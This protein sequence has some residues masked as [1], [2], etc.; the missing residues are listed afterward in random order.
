MAFALFATPACAAA[1]FNV[2]GYYLGQPMDQALALDRTRAATPCG[3]RKCLRF[4]ATYLG[5]AATIGVELDAKEGV[6]RMSFSMATDR[7]PDHPDCAALGGKVVAGV[8]TLYG[9]FT[10][11]DPGASYTWRDDGQKLKITVI[12]FSPKLGTV[13]GFYEKVSALK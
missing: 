1:P 4:D 11:S 12:C 9:R 2:L 10:D 5:R 6:R 8:A 7:E 3:T 13:S